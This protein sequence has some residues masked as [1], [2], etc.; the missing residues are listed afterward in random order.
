MINF[1]FIVSEVKYSIISLKPGPSTPGKDCTTLKHP[2]YLLYFLKFKMMCSCIAYS[3]CTEMYNVVHNNNIINFK[4][5]S[6]YYHC[7]HSDFIL[8]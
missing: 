7:E 6:N 2:E 3:C 1:F 4:T 8:K 5:Y